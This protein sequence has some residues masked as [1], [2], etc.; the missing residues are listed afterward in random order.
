MLSKISPKFN[1]ANFCKIFLWYLFASRHTSRICFSCELCVNLVVVDFALALVLLDGSFKGLL[2]IF[3]CFHSNDETV[4]VV[5]V[6]GVVGAV[7]GVGGLIF[8]IV[9]VEL[10]SNAFFA[11]VALSYFAAIDFD[12]FSLARSKVVFDG[13]D[14]DRD[15]AVDIGDN[16]IGGNGRCSML[17]FM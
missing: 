15:V 5:G 4:G 2:S 9:S 14:G 13:G 10:W 1:F 11:F 12:N 16:D 8:L 3:I 17:R 7:F 6:V